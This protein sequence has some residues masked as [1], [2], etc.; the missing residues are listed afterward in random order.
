MS[1]RPTDQHSAQVK[2][3]KGYEED[4]R[5]DDDTDEMIEDELQIVGEH[6]GQPLPEEGFRCVSKE[7]MDAAAVKWRRPPVTNLQENVAMCF[8][9]IEVDYAICMEPVEFSTDG[10]TEEKAAVI[11][12]F[13][14]TREGCSIVAHV[15]GFRPYFYAKAPPG[16][17]PHDISMFSSSLSGRLKSSARANEQTQ[18]PVLSIELVSRQSIMHYNFQTQSPFLRIVVALPS[19]VPTLRRI[20][21]QGVSLPRGGS[22][23][24][25]TYESNVQF[26]LRF[27][28]DE[29]IVGCNW[30]TVNS[31]K[32][33]FRPWKSSN[34][35]IAPATHCQVN[36]HQQPT[37]SPQA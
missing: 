31:D 29:D 25:E 18:N 33:R 12:M 23:C 35:T 1:K 9:Q 32:S 6:V 28:V 27:M 17:T 37:V 15:H 13:G 11:R 2:K 8:N 36:K 16:F 22:H 14:V 7:D 21:E 4:F 24:F 3:V 19:L 10:D 20:L 34:R 5:F 26:A 30:I